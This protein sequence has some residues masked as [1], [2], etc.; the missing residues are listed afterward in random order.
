MT[1][2]GSVSQTRQSSSKTRLGVV[3]MTTL[4]CVEVGQWWPK[5]K[6]SVQTWTS[7][8]NLVRGKALAASVV[9]LSG[10]QIRMW[11]Y[12]AASR[13]ECVTM[14]MWIRKRFKLVNIQF[15]QVHKSLV[16]N[17]DLVECDLLTLLV[18]ML[19]IF[20]HIYIHNV[21][22]CGLQINV[23]FLRKTVRQIPNN[24][25]CLIVIS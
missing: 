7:R 25:F 23:S 16:L 19:H 21:F 5:G 10:Q 14:W 22:E 24:E 3:S 11:L 6:L 2:S 12:W 4:C 20:I 8:I 1:S 9:L 13:C 18:C 15:A 17:S